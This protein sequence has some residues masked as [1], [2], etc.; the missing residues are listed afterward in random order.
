MSEE[1]IRIPVG[2]LT[3]LVTEV[4]RGD[5]VRNFGK[6]LSI[7]NVRNYIFT[8]EE[9]GIDYISDAI[10]LKTKSVLTGRMLYELIP[11]GEEVEVLMY[12]SINT[13]T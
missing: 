9:L 12:E 4:N 5:V 13:T 1:S 8:D 11:V 2:Y 3:K 10:Q 7:K 6:I